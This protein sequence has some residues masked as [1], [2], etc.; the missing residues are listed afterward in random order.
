[1]EFFRSEVAS[2]GGY[3]YYYSSDLQQIWGEGRV[4]QDTILVQPPGT[5]AVGMALLKAYRSSGEQVCLRASVAAGEALVQGQLRSGGWTQTIDFKP[6]KRSGAYRLRPG[7]R[8][9]TSSLDDDQTQ[10]ALR[11][12][13]ELDGQLEFEHEAIHEAA[14]IGLD[15]LLAA[16]FPGGGFP[17]VWTGPTPPFPALSAN[18]P[19]YDW[20]S[21]GRIKEYWDY[22]TL[23]DGLAGAVAETLIVAERTYRDRRARY[24]LERL[25]DFLVAAQLPAP[26]PA[27]AQQYNAAMQPMWARKFEPPAISSAESQDVIRTLIRIA[28][29]TGRREYLEPIPAALRYLR[30][31]CLL[32]G[33]RF[34]RF[35]ELKTNR[36]LFMNARYELTYSPDEA[37]GHYGWF[38]DSGLDQLTAAY[39]SAAAN[40]ESNPLPGRPAVP[41]ES[42]VRRILMELEERGCWIDTYAGERL[43]GQPDWPR[44]FRYLSSATFARNIGIL[45]AAAGRS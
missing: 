11:F 27:W 36:P 13:M 4:Q 23:N 21:E 8:R 25:G 39:R 18:F 16:Q 10:A 29:H 31:D 34:A 19:Q 33:D 20:R 24:A 30:D 5:P 9:N 12:L 2:H 15:A 38:W 28:R 35:Y 26:Q 7:G 1:M 42:E 17:Q 3:A 45:A 44:G 40:P 41:S 32:A 37:P 43:V 14:Q 22:P 6:D